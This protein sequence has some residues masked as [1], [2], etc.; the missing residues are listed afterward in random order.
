MIHLCLQQPRGGKNEGNVGDHVEQ[1]RP[2]HREGGHVVVLLQDV[3]DDHLE[4]ILLITFG[5]KF[6]EK[7]KK[8]QKSTMASCHLL[9]SLNYINEK[10]FLKNTPTNN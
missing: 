3:S 4:P 5:P 9:V 2:R 8:R 10:V 1:G 7:N 6:R